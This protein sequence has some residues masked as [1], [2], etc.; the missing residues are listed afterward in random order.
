MGLLCVLSKLYLNDN[1]LNALP[2]ELGSLQ[3]LLCTRG[4][5]GRAGDFVARECEMPHPLIVSHD[6]EVQQPSPCARR[7]VYVWCAGSCDV[8]AWRSMIMLCDA[9]DMQ[10][11]RECSAVYLLE[12]NVIE[13][14]RG[15]AVG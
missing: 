8:P 11:H 4:S 14:S 5:T 13:L 1:R 2:A 9:N 15:V 12:T 6:P 3:Q 10:T 7:V